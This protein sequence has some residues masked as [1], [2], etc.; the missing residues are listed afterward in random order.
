MSFDGHVDCQRMLIGPVWPLAIIGKPRVAAPATVPPAA[1]R[2]PR[3]VAFFDGP[4][5]GEADCLRVMIPPGMG[6]AR[7]ERLL[8]PCAETAH[9]EFS[10]VGPGRTIAWPTGGRHWR[11]SAARRAGTGRRS[12][13]ERVRA[14]PSRPRAG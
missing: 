9:G 3:R 13:R 7:D 1:R 5:A 2:K 14:K 4:A 8:W 12:A 6:C 11:P 10:S